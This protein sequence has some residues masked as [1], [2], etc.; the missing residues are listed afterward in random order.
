METDV[1]EIKGYLKNIVKSARVATME[2]LGFSI[3]LFED[4]SDET[5]V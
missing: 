4:T 1:R 5:E 2:E 3:D